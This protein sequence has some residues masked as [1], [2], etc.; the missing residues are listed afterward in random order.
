MA[1]PLLAGRAARQPC[2]VQKAGEDAAPVTLDVVIENGVGPEARESLS[3]F[4]LFWGL[5][6]LGVVPNETIDQ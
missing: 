5:S 1:L 2:R 3:S 6:S 4:R